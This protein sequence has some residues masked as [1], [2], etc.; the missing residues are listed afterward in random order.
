MDVTSVDYVVQQQ[1]KL[2]SI[3]LRH[4][5]DMTPFD[6]NNNVAAMSVIEAFCA[7]SHIDSKAGVGASSKAREFRSWIVTQKLDSGC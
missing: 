4:F 5:L 1:V 7:A 2:G 6:K 3:T